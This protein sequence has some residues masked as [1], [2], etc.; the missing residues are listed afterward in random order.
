MVPSKL[1]W[2]V[3]LIKNCLYGK[4]SVIDECEQLHNRVWDAANTN[5]DYVREDIRKGTEDEK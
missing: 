4:N 5:R 1:R 3:G 2:N